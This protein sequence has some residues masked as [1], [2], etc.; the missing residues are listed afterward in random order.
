MKYPIILNNSPNYDERPHG[1]VVDK[2]IIH[3]TGMLTAEDALNK[4]CDNSPEAK[5]LGRVSAHYMIDE[6]GKIFALVDERDRA[7]HAGLS[8]WQGQININDTSIGI[9]LVNPGHEHGYK[10]FPRA[11]MHALAELGQSI[12]KRNPI[13]PEFVLGHSDIAPGRKVDPGEKFGWRFLARKGVGYWP[14]AES[15]DYARAQFYLSSPTALRYALL[16]FGY[17]PDVDINVI[18]RSF[19]MHYGLTD[20]EEISWET[21]ASL[22]WLCRKMLKD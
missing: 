16:K 20:S 1:A 18:A 6:E 17:N 19:N 2:I 22:S 5:A 14:E 21:A 13:R 9:E 11:Q 12:C 8:F 10:P 4:M 15:E 3:Y 7:W